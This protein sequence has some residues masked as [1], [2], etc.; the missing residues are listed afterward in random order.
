[1]IS[2]IQAGT[3]SFVPPAIGKKTKELHLTSNAHDFTA[4][5][6]GA[7]RH[8]SWPAM[9]AAAS[10]MSFWLSVVLNLTPQQQCQVKLVDH[11]VAWGRTVAGVHYEDDNT[12]GLDMGQEV[13]ARLL[14]EHL[15]NT[16]GSDLTTVQ[17]KVDAMRFS[18][19]EFDMKNPCPG[20]EWMLWHCKS[21]SRRC[22]F[23]DAAS[24]I[25]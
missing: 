6:E 15:A 20:T 17:A 13:V 23:R 21:R 25:A 3:L 5:P 24:A 4:Y 16:Y 22:S 7:P 18:W 11:A 9:H 1:V 12:A 8:P 14:P 19:K 2:A 10:G